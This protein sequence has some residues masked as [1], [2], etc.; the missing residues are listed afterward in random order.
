M[1]TQS[2]DLERDQVAHV[3][4]ETGGDL[5]DES[6]VAT[7]LAT[8]LSWIFHYWT[9]FVPEYAASDFDDGADYRTVIRDNLF[10][11]PPTDLEGGWHKVAT[12]ASSGESECPA[13][14]GTPSPT[15]C[16]LCEAPAGIEHG[17]V[18]IGDG[19]A[20]VVYRGT[21]L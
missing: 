14:A 16:P 3:F 13:G 19:W 11:E 15:P 18:Y 7:E 21:Q 1:S 20:E 10:G 5:Q 12:F 9:E 8:G 17:Y 6:W 2:T 4:G